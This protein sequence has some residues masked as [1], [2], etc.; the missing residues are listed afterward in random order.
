M[1]KNVLK[2]LPMAISILLCLGALF[3]TTFAWFSMN[4]DVFSDSMKLKVDVMPN[5][6][7]SVSSSG[8]AAIDPLDAQRNDTY[9]RVDFDG[10]AVVDSSG[11]I[12]AL[13]PTTHSSG[14]AYGLMY[15]A[16]PEAVGRSSGLST[17]EPLRFG[18]AVNTDAGAY[19]QYYID[20]VIYIATTRADLRVTGITA[21][22]S[23]TIDSV[24]PNAEDTLNAA[25]IDFYVGYSSESVEYKGTLN[26]KG[27]DI[28][29]NRDPATFSILRTKTTQD[30]KPGYVAQVDIP[31]NETG[32]IKV[33]MRCYIDGALLKSSTQAYINT[34]LVDLS[35]IT[36][37][38]HIAAVTP[39]P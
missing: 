8:L 5:L 3:A 24:D 1:K 6:V 19:P 9:Y 15:V 27:Y 32:Y 13:V 18:S 12:R 14:T 39:A 28:E 30:L 17:G 22:L 2:L 7:V 25:S 29:Y 37:N 21:T 31:F 23:G 34:A 16:N 35:D 10:D 36:L 38:V 33:L 20:R 11:T 26:V 4:K